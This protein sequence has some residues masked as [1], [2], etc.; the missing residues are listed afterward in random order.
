MARGQGPRQPLALFRA[1]FPTSEQ[2]KESVAMAHIKA[3]RQKW[4]AAAG[5]GAPAA[6]AASGVVS[7]KQSAAEAPHA[8]AEGQRQPNGAGGTA[9][10]LP[11]KRHLLAQAERCV[12]RQGPSWALCFARW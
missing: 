3:L 1:A 5:V 7:R 10:L 8:Q 12:Q 4:M 9:T 2:L 6:P 11:K